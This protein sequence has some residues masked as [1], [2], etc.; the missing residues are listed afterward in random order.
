MKQLK[1]LILLFCQSFSFQVKEHVNLPSET[2]DA[3]QDPIF[4]KEWF[5]MQSQQHPDVHLQKIEEKKFLDSLDPKNSLPFTPEKETEKKEKAAAEESYLKKMALKHK[6]EIEAITERTRWKQAEEQKHHDDLRELKR[7]VEYTSPALQPNVYYDTLHKI[8]STK[9]PF[10]YDGDNP[11]E[12]DYVLPWNYHKTNVTTASYYNQGVQEEIIREQLKNQ[13]K[14]DPRYARAYQFAGVPGKNPYVMP[15]YTQNQ[16]LNE[17]PRLEES[18]AQTQKPVAQSSYT[19][20]YSPDKVKTVKTLD[21]DMYDVK[22]LS[23]SLPSMFNTKQTAGYPKNG[24]KNGLKNGVKISNTAQV[25]TGGG[26]SPLQISQTSTA[27]PASDPTKTTNL[28]DPVG[29]D[30]AYNPFVDGRHFNPDGARDPRLDWFPSSPSGPRPQTKLLKMQNSF[31]ETGTRE[32]FH[33]TFP[34]PSPDLRVNINTGKKHDFQGLNA[35]E[36]H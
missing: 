21:T 15:K 12:H 13:I 30:P 5:R 36:M 24:L 33:G 22:E 2:H 6:E 26:N 27:N 14:I 17:R 16:L 34:E 7:K 28:Y 20:S 1:T 25:A 19:Y 3:F 31:T 18:V 11:Y 32:G 9:P 4:T 8:Y 23:K 10:Y 35:C 29:Q